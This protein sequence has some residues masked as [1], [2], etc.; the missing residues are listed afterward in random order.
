LQPYTVKQFTKNEALSFTTQGSTL[1]HKLIIGD[2]YDALQ[3][4]LGEYK[5]KVD[6]IYIDP[7]YG[8][9]GTGDFAQTNYDNAI[10]RADLLSMLRV[11]LVLAQQLL[12]EGGVIYCSIDDKNHAYVKCLFDEIFGERNF[13]ENFI[14]I[15]NSGGSLTHF[16]LTRHEYVLFYC[17]DKTRCLA[18]NPEIFKIQKQGFDDVYAQ[19]AQYQHDGLTIDQAKTKL[20]RFYKSRDDLKGIKMYD[21]IDQHWQVYRLLP[22]TAPNNNYYEVLHP[23]TRKPVKTPARGWSWSQKTMERHI[24]SGK[25]VF[26]ADEKTVPSQKLYLH[27][28]QYEQKRSTF[29]ADQ[30]EGNKTLQSILGKVNAFHNPKPLSLMHYLLTGSKQSAIILDFFAGSGT[31]G[32][33]VL[34]L[35]QTDGGHRQFILATSNE[36]TKTTPNGIAYDVTAKRLKRV[37]T[38]TCYDDIDHFKWLEKNTPFGGN[39][40]VYEIALYLHNQS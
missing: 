10:T 3:H 4:L 11:R 6:V 22:I 12:N 21:H 2:N 18:Q 32:Q 35:N 13:V 38:G 33:A 16:T 37:M 39:M 28:S 24:Q 30:A 25:V 34:A 17:K 31:T 19:I 14:F 7:P 9:D 8:M 5:N 40:D 23:M 20:R 27:D 26:G 1:T 36:K 29:Q 15:K